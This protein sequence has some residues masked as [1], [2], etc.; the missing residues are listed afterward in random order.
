VETPRFDEGQQKAT[1]SACQNIIDVT[2]ISDTSN[3]S[4]SVTR[5]TTHPG[6]VST[7]KRAYSISEHYYLGKVI[8]QGATGA[9]H[10]AEYHLTR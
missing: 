2:G 6:T 10:L 5:Q 1:V 3:R 8:G 9:V 7:I 4:I